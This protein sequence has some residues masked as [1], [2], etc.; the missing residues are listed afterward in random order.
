MPKKTKKQKIAAAKRKHT[1]F[2][3]SEFNNFKV[4][5]PSIKVLKTEVKKDSKPFVDPK[6]V[7]EFKKDL[8]KSLV[9]TFIILSTTVGL[10]L[11]RESGF[12]S[13]LLNY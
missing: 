10:Y 4:E 7:T 9:L 6:E 5:T 3:Q 8:F 13:V 12:I 11:A 1:V 2:L